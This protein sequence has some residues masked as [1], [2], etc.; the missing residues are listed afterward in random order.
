MSRPTFKPEISLGTLVQIAVILV[1]VAVAW[2]DV[3]SKTIANADAIVR[4]DSYQREISLRQEREI[5]AAKQQ[6]RVLETSS[7]RQD[8]RYAAIFDLLGRIDARLERIEE[9]ENGR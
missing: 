6:I 8:E 4:N 2:Q 7:A 1:T 3:R 9:A 5:Q